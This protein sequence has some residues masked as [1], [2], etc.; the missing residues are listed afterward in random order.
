[1]IRVIKDDVL[2]SQFQKQGFVVVPFMDVT[3]LDKMS[4]LFH[5]YCHNASYTANGIFYSLFANSW[6]DKL[7]LRDEIRL[8][9]KESY[10]RTF[11]NYQPFAESFLA[12]AKTTED[13]LLHQDWSYAEEGRHF[14]ATVWCPLSDVDEQNGG[15]FVLPGSQHFFTN[16]RSG[17]L[18]TT[19]LTPNSR[20]Q[21]YLMPL[22]VRKGEAVIFHQG[23]FHGSFPNTTDTVRIVAASVILEAGK[24]AAYYHQLSTTEVGLF[25]MTDDV[26][27][28][29]VESLAAMKMPVAA[30]FKQKIPYIHHSVSAEDLIRKFE[31]QHIPA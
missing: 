8:V 19:R 6:Q 7:K 10:E 24:S 23:L 16:F 21:K 12:K 25:E 27:L 17:T 18:P 2:H 28:G 15:L 9:W 13:L 3:Q 30:V 14:A 31:E 11:I 1:M 22:K 26:F 5:T 29:E 4:A 20:L